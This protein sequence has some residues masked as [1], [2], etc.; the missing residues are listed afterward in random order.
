METVNS[1]YSIAFEVPSAWEA[2]PNAIPFPSEL[3]MRIH[4]RSSGP[5]ITPENPAIMTNTTV[6]EGTPPIPDA[7]CMATGVVIDFGIIDKIKLR[8]MPNSSA[9]SR[10]LT[11]PENKPANTPPMI[12]NIYL[13]NTR[14]CL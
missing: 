7:I 4:L 3:R 8:L 9:N 10:P 13:I 11:I 12:G 14:R 6:M 5:K 1:P 2:L